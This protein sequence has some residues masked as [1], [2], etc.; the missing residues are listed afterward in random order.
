MRQD[1]YYR[2]N[3]IELIV[4]PLRERREDLPLLCQTLLAR[5]ANEAGSPPLALTPQLMHDIASQ[6]LEGNVRELENL[7]HRAVALGEVALAG[8]PGALD[9]ADAARIAAGQRQVRGLF[10]PSRVQDEKHRHPKPH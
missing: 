6:P 5:I 8:S 4:P 10:H 9:W 3:V 1:L 7:L 2:L